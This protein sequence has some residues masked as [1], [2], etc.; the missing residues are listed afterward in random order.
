MQ[1]N[2]PSYRYL[3]ALT[4]LLIPFA[5]PAAETSPLQRYV[6]TPDPSYSYE[7]IG[8]ISVGGVVAHILSM[9]SQ[10]WRSA[11]EVTP[12]IWNHW[13]TII[14]PQQLA[15]NRANLTIVGGS[16]STQ[17]PNAADVAQ[18]SLIATA[19]GTIQVVV[20][21]VP[22]QPLLFSDLS[23]GLSEDALVAY[24]W[25]KLMQ[26]GD[27]TWAVYLP[28]TKAAV[29]AMDSAEDFVAGNLGLEID[30]FIVTGF[31]KRGA[32]AWLTAAVD[33]RVVAVVP[34]MFNMLHM[35][36][37]LEHH[38]ASY[39]F[40][41]DALSD[42]E[43]N[44]V[45]DE[46]RAPEGKLLRQIVDPISYR[47]AL[48]MPHLIINSSGDEF[49]L[50][51][52]SE[53]YIHEL[54]A[55]ALQ[56]IVPNTDHSAE[57]K[58]EVIL[59]GLIAWYQMQLNG[60]Q[61]PQLEWNLTASGELEVS[62]DQIPLF[63]RLWQ[64]SNPTARDF[65]HETVGD[66]AWQSSL[67]RADADGRYR[68]SVAT[69]AQGYTAYMVELTYS[70]AAGLPQVYTTSV[71]VTPDEHP[72]ELE[73][74]LLDPKNPLYWRRQVASAL[75]GDPDDYTGS[76]LEQMLPIRVLGDYVFDLESLDA[77][78][79]QPGPHRACSAAR[80]NVEANEV[81]WYS[82]LYSSGERK[83]RYWQPYDVAEQLYSDGNESLAAGICLWL[84]LQ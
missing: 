34:G 72:F 67:I 60:L 73:E 79:Q 8:E 6:E 21:Q 81:G 35:A 41:S 19:T 38:Y 75:A 69:P 12:V 77:L 26:T 70:G 10:S 48:T 16:T 54:P 24:S 27:P 17:P 78:L 59:S 82:T 57:A 76:E 64:A 49:F 44:A 40:F 29:R 50:P 45:M 18:F 62:T 68:V 7:K 55:E 42:Y 66:Q 31:S 80:L 28:M 71:F 74:P 30:R 84:T 32:T 83:I 65:R 36:D 53:R 43:A 56:R 37:Q 33:D 13:V 25:R 61:R 5:L 63:A 23:E 3:L 14:V 22:S 15:S 20:Q 9:N 51:D 58:F 39:G 52:A 47:E 1:R 2:M 11:D 46:I 4:F